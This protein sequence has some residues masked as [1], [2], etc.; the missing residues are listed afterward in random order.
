MKIHYQISITYSYCY[1]EFLM[2]KNVS[3]T[4]TKMGRSEIVSLIYLYVV[5]ISAIKAMLS[6]KVIIIELRLALKQVCN[7]QLKKYFRVSNWS[8]FVQGGVNFLFFK[9]FGRQLP[10]PTFHRLLVYLYTRSC[11]MF[12]NI[13]ICQRICNENIWKIF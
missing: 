2:L 5:N 3:F 9:L 8:K 12:I 1:V 6:T 4:L 13:I 7:S 10:L 11:M